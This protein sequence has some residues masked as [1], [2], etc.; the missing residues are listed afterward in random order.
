[1]FKYFFTKIVLLHLLEYTARVGVFYPIQHTE[2][3]PLILELRIGQ[4]NF[5]SSGQSHGGS[6]DRHGVS[7]STCGRGTWCMWGKHA[8]KS[9]EGTAGEGMHRARRHRDRY[10]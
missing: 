6:C 7:G 5:C 4:A 10:T 8:G 3:K 9:G 1:M 2:K